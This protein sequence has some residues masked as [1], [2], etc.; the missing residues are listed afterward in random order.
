MQKKL[1][2]LAVAAAFS[3]PAFA[4]TT[5]YGIIDAAVANVSGS[6]QKSD[7]LAISGG[8][9]TSRLGVKVT[10]DL[11]NGL[12]AVGVLEYGLDS[13][14][15]D[16]IGGATTKARQKM[17]AV[18]GSFGTVA[19]G[20]LQTTGYDFAVAFDPVAGSLASPLQNVTA[21]GSFFIGTVAKAARAARA[22]AY[23]S[24]NLSGV[25]LAANYS[26]S[27][28]DGGGTLGNLGQ[29]SS[30]TVPAKTTAYLFSA[31]YANGPLTAGAV[32]LGATAGTSYLGAAATATVAV[33]EYAFGGSYDLGVAK[34]M[35]TYQS[36]KTG[37]A[38]ANTAL[39]LSGVMPISTGAIAFTFAKNSMP[40][41]G[42]GQSTSASGFT[43]GYLHTLSKTTT[44]YAAYSSMSQGVGTRSYSVANN[45]LAAAT[46]DLGGSS[47]L[48]AVGLRKKF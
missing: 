38:A 16:A 40:A 8:A 24:P 43:A 15:T 20:Y 36:N 6:G 32:Y 46:L 12:T 26:T 2:A 17:L 42:A 18:A 23:I 7:L 28:L 3:A 1:I 13:Q 25:T 47:S 30:A 22:L 27:V 33:T 31:N 45:G 34:L 39:S 21:G 9:S 10:E 48:I 11:G 35:G 29:A 14:N 44:A 4:D 37:A 19:T 41:N 5:A